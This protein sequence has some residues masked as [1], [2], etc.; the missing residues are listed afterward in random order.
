MDIT[1]YKI[2]FIILL[3]YYYNLKNREFRSYWYKTGTPT[4]LIKLI[5]QQKYDV[6][7]LDNIILRENI[8]EKFDLDY[9]M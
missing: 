4:F 5:K 3:I 2:R 7:K 8:L 9:R 1:F 6:T